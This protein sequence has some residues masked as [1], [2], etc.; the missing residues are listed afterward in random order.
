MTGKEYLLELMPGLERAVREAGCIIRENWDKPRAINRKGRIDLVTD[1][2]VA[3]EEALLES[4]SRVLPEADFLAEESSAE[5]EVGEMTWVIDPLDGTTNF[6]HRLPFVGI[7]V[8][9]WH[10]DGVKA[11]IVYNPMLEECFTAIKGQGALLNGRSIQVSG[12]G[13]LEESVV[14]TGFPYAIR[15][16]ATE[17]TGWLEKVLSTTQG[18]RRYG[19]AAVDLAYVACGRLDGFYEILL[20]PWDTAAGWLLVEEAGG[21][22]SRF[23]ESMP[24]HLR[25]SNLLATNGLIHGPL[26]SLLRA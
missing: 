2:D 15:E 4:L 19:A 22:V 26:S 7:S 17:I 20:S 16:H 25:A 10:V 23:D 21:R 14:G 11:G 12:S 6:A 13:T 1:T 24:F 3:V 8:A 5:Q 18:V 9:L